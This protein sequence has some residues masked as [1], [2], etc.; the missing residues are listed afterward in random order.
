MGIEAQFIESDVMDVID[1]VDERFDI[2]F[3][4]TGV[5]CWLPDIDRYAQ[6]VRHLLNDDG[7][8]YILDGHPFRSVLLD[9]N[10]ESGGSTI[11]GDYFR[12]Q[13]WQYDNLGD[14]TDPDLVIPH[15]SY[16]WHWTMGEVVTA[17]CRAGM[18]IS[19]LHEFPQYFY[20][21]YTPHDVSDHEVELYPCTFSLKAT[22]T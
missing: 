14:Y 6:T 16:E 5:L 11:Q 3:S 10:G 4:S 12:K 2:V 8:F 18:R 17:F 21:G 7:F 22:A 15:R 13:A 9:C 20:N 1:V 19:F